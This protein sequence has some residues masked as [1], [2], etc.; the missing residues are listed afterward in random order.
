MKNIR[1]CALAVIASLAITACSTAHVDTRPSADA[2]AAYATLFPYYAE[3]CAVSELKKKPGFGAALA[4]GVGGHAILY[5]NGACRDRRAG[6]PVIGLCEDDAPGEERGVGLSVNAHFKNA[7]WVATPGRDFLF[8]G[9]LRPGERLT[10]AVYAQTQATAKAKG[11]Y[12]GVEFHDGVFA[13]MPPQ[14]SRREYQYEVSVATDYGIGFGRDRYCT[15]VPLDRERM[16]AL[17]AY[18]NELNMPYRSGEKMFDWNV[19]NNNCS[20]VAHNALAAARVWSEWPMDRFLLLAAFSFPVPKNEF[21]NLTWR[22]ND[23]P[24]DDIE[25]IYS[26][27][28]ARASLMGYGTLP[29]APGA[30]AEA[31][32]AAPQNDLYDT[33]LSLIF[34]DDPIFGTYQPRFARIFAEQRY[35]DLEANLRHFADLYRRIEARRRPRD[36]TLADRP[37]AERADFAEVYDRYYRHIGRA[38]AALDA[39]LAVL[40]HLR[41]AAQAEEA[42]GLAPSATIRTPSSPGVPHGEGG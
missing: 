41:P 6:Y 37:P 39:E 12:D 7:V 10:R 35:T 32:P 21:V 23:M 2:E 17:I 19:L 16:A 42:A 1:S 13:D 30:L 8:H 24:I 29:T 9:T 15:R 3:L 28:A 11:I 33:A 22:A 14:M 20:H 25:A 34:Y 31:E 4:S 27:R 18:L 26:D 36:E 38:S 40:A 5:L